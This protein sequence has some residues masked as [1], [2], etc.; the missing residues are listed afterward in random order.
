MADIRIPDVSDYQGAVN[1]QQVIAS[2]RAGGICKASEGTGY[3]AKTFA[4]NWATLDQLGAVRGAYCF[5]RPSLSAPAVQ[6][7]KFLATVATW[8]PADLLV[9]DLE[10]G[11]G[12]LSGW[13]LQWLALVRDA[14]GIIP[15]LYS[16][17]PFIKAHL[18]AP[19]LA[20]Y[21]LW[22]AA[23]QSQPPPCPTPWKTYGLWQQTDK[24]QIPGIRGACDESVGNLP[25]VAPAPVAPAVV[26]TE[27]VPIP[28]HDFEEAA[29]KQTMVH[30]GP[31][32]ANG[33]GWADWPVG[34]G[35]DPN[36]VGLVQLGPSP[37]DDG[38]WPGQAKVTLA[39]QPRAGALRVTVRNGTPG[40]T[41][42]C[43]A[44]VS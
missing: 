29:V 11:S 43:F 9:L 31:L 30:V 27:S 38:Y 17:G 32:D 37:P 25:V 4:G 41:I 44:T 36:V 5:A 28:V 34:L 18:T 8:K 19:A 10:D 16:Y 12:D 13:A 40:D 35:R 26:R 39:A 33:N 42:T 6:A 1:W 21:P 24:A 3:T 22:L 2:G 23:Y 7:R 15:W 20:A 14:T